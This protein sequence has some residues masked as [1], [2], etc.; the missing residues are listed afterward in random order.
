VATAVVEVANPIR[1]PRCDAALPPEAIEATEMALC[2]NCGAG[3]LVRS[4]PAILAKPA[5]ILPAEIAA[6][7]GE[8][9][10][11]FHPGKTATVACARCGRFVCRLCQMD[12]RGEALCPECITSGMAKK[13]IAVLENHRVCYDSIA[14]ALATWPVLLVWFLTFLSAPV[15]L[16]VAIRYWKAPLSILGRTKL[17]FVLAILLAT[18]EIALWAWSAVYAISWLGTK[19]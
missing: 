18:G 1:C 2:P 14:L 4:F 8:A 5:A 7:E 16:Y 17:R 3:V 13:K 9:T 10:C 11:F 12:L 6:G 19:G 15:A